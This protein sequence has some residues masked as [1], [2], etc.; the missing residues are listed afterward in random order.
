MMSEFSSYNDVD[1]SFIVYAATM[2][3]QDMKTKSM[4]ELVNQKALQ[5]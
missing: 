1:V 3:N 4:K 5:N 2:L